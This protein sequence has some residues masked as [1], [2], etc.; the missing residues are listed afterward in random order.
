LEA[1]ACRREE[2]AG[3]EDDAPPEGAEDD[4]PPEA[5]EAGAGCTPSRSPG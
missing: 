2:A 3:A 5:A 1:A 4:G